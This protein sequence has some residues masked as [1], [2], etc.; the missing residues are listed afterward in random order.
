MMNLKKLA[1]A[2]LILGIS[3]L[4]LT[5]L[6]Q[7]GGGQGRGGF[8]QR[9]GG[10]MQMQNSKANLV[11]RSDVRKDI[12]TTADQNTKLDALQKE[13]RE[14]MRAAFQGMGG[15]Q[16]QGGQ[17]QGGQ[18]PDM[19]EIQKK[20]TEMN[21]TYEEGVLKVLDEAQAKRLGQISLQMQGNSALADKKIQEE[22]KF[23][24]D[25]KRKVDDLQ[26]SMDAANQAIFQRVQ[27]GEIDRTEIQPLM[28]ENTKILDAELAKI[29]TADQ[30]K[31]FDEMKGAKFT[32][33]PKV[34]EEMRNQRGGR[35]GGGN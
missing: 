9:G 13:F 12:K 18:R 35:G 28:A 5:A 26:S 16:R 6:A 24:V 20:M 27:N 33:D 23:T 7:Q 30:T 2:T 17:G 15:G 10:M 21:K 31:A 25:Q 14:Q 29:L 1:V 8:G 34:D 3:V 19:T 11:A 4:P 32:R 22:L